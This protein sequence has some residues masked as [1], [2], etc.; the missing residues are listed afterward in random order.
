MKTALGQKVKVGLPKAFQ[1][2]EV[3]T[4]SLA[5]QPISW[6]QSLK[7]SLISIKLNDKINAVA[8]RESCTA[9]KV[10]PTPK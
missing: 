4:K 9:T 6:K 7:S 1:T 2:S 5:V 10:I 8:V 3:Q